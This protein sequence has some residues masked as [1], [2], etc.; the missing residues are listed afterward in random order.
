MVC[1]INIRNYLKLMP[2]IY[3]PVPEIEKSITR[4]VVLDIVRQVKEITGIPEETRE[5]FLGDAK[6]GLQA[7]STV[8]SDILDNTNIAAYKQITLEVT[9]TYNENNLGTVAIAQ[10]EQNPIFVDNYLGVLLKPVYAPKVFEITV[11]Y[12]SSSKTESKA[13][14][15]NIYMHVNHLRDVNLHDATYHYSVPK[16][17]MVLLQEIHRLREN[18][19][20]YGDTFDDYFFSNSTIMNTEITTLT[21]DKTSFAVAENQIRIQGLFSFTDAPEKEQMSGDANMWM[22]EFTYKVTIDIPV[23]MHMQ[24]PIMVHNQLLDEKYIPKPAEDDT[25]HDKI[26]SK[27][28]KAMHR[29]EVPYVTDGNSPYAPV[30]KVPEYDDWLPDNAIIGSQPIISCLCEL[31]PDDKKLLLNLRELGDYAIDEEILEYFQNV[32]YRYLTLPYKSLFHVSLYRNKFLTTDRSTLVD[33]RLNF[34]STQDLE[35]RRNYRVVFSM[36][37][38][39]SSVDPAALK[40]MRRYPSVLKKALSAI[41]VTYAQLARLSPIVDLTGFMPELTKTG[42]NKDYIFGQFVRFHTVLS[43]H[44]TSKRINALG[45]ADSWPKR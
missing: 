2:K 45:K 1:Y 3:L 20:G 42:A 43:S 13:W 21:G 28:F 12:R 40:R 10:P 11:R 41:K 14:R 30:V 9:E 19:E 27:S 33:S 44:V 7:G 23:G 18:V 34:R 32:E 5:I 22:S 29:F 16:P 4:P 31:L 26:F 38:D 8:N 15:D 37:T 35:L 25:K 6:S 36:L 24:Y 17:F 39:I